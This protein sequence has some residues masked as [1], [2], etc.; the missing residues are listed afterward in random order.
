MS[1]A[2]IRTGFGDPKV[3]I[4][5]GIFVFWLFHRVQ[6]VSLRTMKINLWRQARGDVNFR[7]KEMLPINLNA[8]FFLRVPPKTDFIM[9]AARTLGPIMD[10]IAM[11]LDGRGLS[12][13][14]KGA[15]NRLLGHASGSSTEESARVGIDALA[16]LTRER[17]Q[18][19]MREV[20]A[21]LTVEELHRDHDVIADK[22]EYILEADLRKNGLELARI[23]IELI[24]PEPLNN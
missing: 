15:S 16:D 3:I 22:V 14:N 20:V 8:E 1:E 19:A 5:G 23:A 18:R 13:P 4:S 11:S 7:S 12:R 21:Q 2:L 6:R 9:A 10:S 24:D 17:F